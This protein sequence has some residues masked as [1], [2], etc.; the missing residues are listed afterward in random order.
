VVALYT[1]TMFLSATLLFGAQPMFARMVL[2]ALGGSPAVWNTAVVFYQVALLGG[3]LYAYASAR[4]LPRRAQIIVHAV[5]V[6]LPLLV[7][8]IAVPGG[9]H[10]PAASS[11]IPWLLALLLVAV[12]LPFFVVSTSSP[13]LQSWFARTRHHRAHDPY[14]LYAASNIGS[15]LAL[16]AYPVLIEPRLGLKAQSA[17]WS[18]GYAALIAGVLACAAVVWRFR[19][20]LPSNP[21]QEAEEPDE[22]LSISRRVR[23]VLLACAPSSLMLSVTT[24]LT[25]DIAPVPLLWTVPLGLYLLTFIL[26]FSERRFLPHRTVVRAFPFLVLPLAMLLIAGSRQPVVPL[27][28]VHLAMFFLIA[29]LCHGELAK[30]RPHA[31]HVTEFYLWLSVGGALGGLVTALVA[32]A[33]FETVREYPLMLAL[34]CFLG[35]PAVRAG[36]GGGVGWIWPCP[37]CWRC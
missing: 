26:V 18:V 1:V 34:V 30:D 17:I 28:I 14:F 11:P 10:P 2:P 9:W 20:T 21:A 19:F 27:M 35:V 29:M 16:F 33:L 5:L 6:L 15:M 37:P 3:Y 25:S 8:P 23:W 12:G 4:W 32:P 36:G 24:Y 31:G 22:R 13:L 7:L